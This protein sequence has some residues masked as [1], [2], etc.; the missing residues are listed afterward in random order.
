MHD[1]VKRITKM[2]PKL[3]QEQLQRI[4]KNVANE[5]AMLD[6]ILESLTTG[7]I[8]V[9]KQWRILKFNKI[10]ERFLS[11]IHFEDET[12]RS[13]K[14]VWEVISDVDVSEFLRD[15]ADKDKS[16][17]SQEFSIPLPNSDN[18]TR[19]IVVYVLSLV[20]D[21]KINGRIIKI[22]DVTEQRLQEVKMRRME[23]MAGLTTLA[24]NMAHEIKNPLG[25]ISIHIQLLQ[26]A[27]EKQRNSTG[28]LPEKKF[29]EEHLDV[30]NE[31]IDNLNRLIT[32]FL[33]AVRPVNANYSLVDPYLILKKLVD[34]LSPEFNSH[35]VSFTVKNPNSAAKLLIDEKIFREMII[36][37]VQNA[38]AAIKER[39]PECKNEDLQNDEFIGKISIRISVKFDKYIISISDNGCG[40]SDETIVRLFEPYFTTRAT[41]TGLGMT[42]VYK[43]VK[44]FSGDIHVKSE[45]NNGTTFIIEL[46]I[47][48][49]EKKLIGDDNRH[50]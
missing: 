6:S 24:A 34:F 8:V 16:N 3:S 22:Y 9:D 13:Y 27:I 47:P 33:F 28:V 45:E 26:K 7:L 21:S 23:N 46:P 19:F 40:M 44:E 42:L 15:C 18:L 14:K 5:N 50:D 35:R 49:T 20:S 4:I 43:I 41:G 38:F 10:S 12:N 32:D 29:V 17:I 2:I 37:I 48:Q 30:V 11:F 31:E 36:N 39:F 25:A 1:Y